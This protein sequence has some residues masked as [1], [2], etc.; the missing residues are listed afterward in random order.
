VRPTSRQR[1][2]REPPDRSQGQQRSARAHAARRDPEAPRAVLRRG[3]RHHRDEHLLVERRIAQADYALEHLAYELNKRSA[4]VA[5]TAAEIW[6]KK[7]PD[8]P[9]F[10]AGAIGPDEPPLS[11]SPEVDDPSFRAVTFDQVKDAYVEQ[12][13]APPRR[14][15]RPAPRR[16][17]LRHAEREGRHL[18]DGGGLREASAPRARDDLRRPSPIAAAARSRARRSRPS[19]PP[20]RTR[21][22]SRSASTARSARRTC[23]PTSRSSRAHR[24]RAHL[25]LPERG[26]AQ[27]VRRLRRA[28]ETT[29]AAPRVRRRAASSTSSAAAAARRPRTSRDREA[30]DGVAPRRCP[31]PT[32]SRASFM[33]IG[34]RTNVTG[35]KRFEAD[36]GG[37]L[38]DGPRGRARSGARRRQHPRRQHGRGDARLARRR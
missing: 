26:P 21:G 29:G 18:R 4:E 30:V 35:S 12:I 11:I 9:R 10:V 37:R 16:D 32:A 5:R 34:E 22:R 25:L 31:R 38:H 7:T 17:D 1:G 28:P 14:R 6:T 15:R 33:M 27:R 20:S 8:K 2:T 36:Q 23:A 19:G 13:E 24:R 3:R